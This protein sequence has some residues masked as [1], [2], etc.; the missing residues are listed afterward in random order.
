MQNAH[1]HKL[2]HIKNNVGLSAVLAGRTSINFVVKKLPLF[3]NLS[4]VSAGA[5]P[6]NATELLGRKELKNIM[7]ELHEQ[8][9]MV[10][11]DTPPLKSNSGAE[12]IAQACCSSIVVLRKNFTFIEEAKILVDVLRENR[13]DIIGTVMTNF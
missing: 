2:F 7:S 13:S 6:P 11:I 9:E 5:P 10:I 12:I 3:R 4:I 8:F 1:L